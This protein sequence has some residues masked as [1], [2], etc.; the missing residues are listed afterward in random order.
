MKNIAVLLTVF[1]RKKKTL[2]CLRKLYDQRIPEAYSLEV[3]MVDDGS[4]DGTSNAVALEF[5]KVNV[6]R[7]N[8]DLFWNRG[9]HKAWIEAMNKKNYDFYLWLNDDTFIFEGAL[10]T[11]ILDSKNKDDRSIICGTTQSLSG[12][13]LS[14]GGRNENGELI[15]P[16]NVLKECKY[17]NGNFVLIPKFVNDLVGTIDP[18]FRHSI[19]DLDYGL[20]A[21]KKGVQVFV[22][23]KVIGACDNHQSLPKWCL[24]DIPLK[25]RLKSLYSPLGNSHP[26]YFFIYENR[27]HGLLVA[28]KHFFT[29]HLRALFPRLWKI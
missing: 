29:I 14:Y 5:P 7:G 9:M 19:G 1:N 23:S 17:M 8:G 2:E 12:S 18:V 3:Y 15:R 25:R 22:A 10:E 6:I 24:I 4:S 11:I 27:H 13:K 28:M 16:S 21:Q 26:Y 20:R